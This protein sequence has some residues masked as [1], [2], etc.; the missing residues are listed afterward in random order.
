M[1]FAMQIALKVD[2]LNQPVNFKGDLGEVEHCVWQRHCS[3]GGRIQLES[4]N[5]AGV[6]EFDVTLI[7][8]KS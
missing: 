6:S 8:R 4:P 1:S 3:N 7:S 2:V 5:E